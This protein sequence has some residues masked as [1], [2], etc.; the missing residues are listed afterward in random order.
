MQTLFLFVLPSHEIEYHVKPG[1]EN[2]LFPD[3]VVFE[4]MTRLV[5]LRCSFSSWRQQLAGV[6]NSN[7]KSERFFPLFC[8]YFT[9]F[10]GLRAA[11]L[12]SHAIPQG[13]GLPADDYCR[14]PA[15]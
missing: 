14:S 4:F 8:M 13:L 5:P 1:L 11:H 2:D 9:V 7:K 3:S 6:F 12:H 15:K 10:R